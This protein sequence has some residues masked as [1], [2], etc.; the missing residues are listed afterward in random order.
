MYLLL[1]DFLSSMLPD[2]Y[3]IRENFLYFSEGEIIC[4]STA[5]WS[6]MFFCINKTSPKAREETLRS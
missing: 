5:Y 3:V 2:F 4:D 1:M 6:D